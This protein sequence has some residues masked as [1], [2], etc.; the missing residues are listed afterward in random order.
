[1]IQYEKDYPDVYQKDRARL[2]Q[3]G[4]EAGVTFYKFEPSVEKWFIETAYKAAWDYQMERFPKET[5][6]LRELLSKK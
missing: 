3:K 1:M 2:K 5:P 4:Q 6:K